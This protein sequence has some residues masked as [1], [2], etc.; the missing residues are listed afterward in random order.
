MHQLPGLAARVPCFQNGS[1]ATVADIVDFYDRRYG[2][3]FSQMERQDLMNFLSVLP[4]RKDGAGGGCR[5][6]RRQGPLALG[7]DKRSVS[8]NVD[9][10]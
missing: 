2:M 4:V 5:T 9:A 7:Q 8:V 6:G 1:A 10:Q 3:A